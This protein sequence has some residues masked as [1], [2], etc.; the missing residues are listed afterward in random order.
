[1]SSQSLCEKEEAEL[2]YLIL[3][4]LETSS[5]ETTFQVYKDE[6][7]NRGLL[8]NKLTYEAVK[9]DTHLNVIPPKFLLEVLRAA[10]TLLRRQ[11][12]GEEYSSV[13]ERLL[14]SAF[15]DNDGR[16]SSN[17][18]GDSSGGSRPRLLSFLCPEVVSAIS[19]INCHPMNSSLTLPPT[20]PTQVIPMRKLFTFPLQINFIFT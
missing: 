7:A 18:D 13:T 2:H 4:F 8:P 14:S 11:E 20:V 15:S 16:N 10:G 17:N 9:E 5:C 12:L 1:M 19:R 3:S 6:A